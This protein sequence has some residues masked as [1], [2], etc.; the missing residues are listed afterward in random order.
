MKF[1]ELLPMTL[2]GYKNEPTGHKSY[3]ERIKNGQNCKPSIKLPHRSEGDI[4][5]CE[6]ICFKGNFKHLV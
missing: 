2:K 3:A 4:V 1:G 5:K 6:Y